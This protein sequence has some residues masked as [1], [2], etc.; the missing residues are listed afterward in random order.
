MVPLRF[1]AG[2]KGKVVESLSHGLPL[3]TTSVGVQ[4]IPGLREVVPVC[5]EPDAMAENLALLLT[6]DA[7]WLHQSQAQTAFAADRFS[8][9]SDAA[10][11]TSGLP[12]RGSRSDRRLPT[13]RWPQPR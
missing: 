9:G 7:A 2:V 4:G 6:D 13:R 3:V 8:R 5:D 10:L 11:R 12:P 1:G